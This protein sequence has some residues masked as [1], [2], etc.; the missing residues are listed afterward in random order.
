LNTQIVKLNYFVVFD[1]WGKKMFETSDISK[2]WDG[3]IDGNPAPVGVYIW[4]ADGFCLSGKR[5]TR[6]GNVTLLR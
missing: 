6:S 3:N 2:G 1:R 5:F 4:E